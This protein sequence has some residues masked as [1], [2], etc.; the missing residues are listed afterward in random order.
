[1]VTLTL[2]LTGAGKPF[3]AKSAWDYVGGL[4]KPSK[5][6]WW[7]YS[8][9]ATACI[10]GAALRAAGKHTVCGSCYA[11]KGF[12]GFPNVQAALERRLDALTNKPRFVEAFTTLLDEK[13][14]RARRPLRFRWFDSGDLP[15]LDAL[16]RI[17]AI[18]RNLHQIRFWLPTREHGIVSRFLKTETFPD[19]L[20]VRMST[21]LIGAKPSHQP[22]GLP[23]SAVGRDDDPELHQCPANKQ[24]G[25]C[26][27]CDAC[28]TDANVSYERH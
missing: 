1:M 13:A 17:V 26:L 10:T 9:P 5:M 25:K 12:Y 24:G 8:T 23:F 19:N 27:D 3:D 7:S 21:A 4:S 2:P 14:K 6:P 20:T 15:S 22:F 11:L 28:W 18:A 16:Q